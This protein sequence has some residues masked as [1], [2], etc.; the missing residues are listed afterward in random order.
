MGTTSSAAGLGA[1]LPE[2][3]GLVDRTSL[4][5]DLVAGLLGA[6]LV[7]P[8]GVA[9]ATL[10]GLPPQYGIYSAVVPC[11]VAALFGS[12]WHVM[13]G[14]TNANS[15]ALFAMLAPLAVPGSP[16]YVHLALTVTVLVGA[17]QFLVG[18]GRLG[19]LANFISPSVLLGFTCGAAALIAVHALKEFLGLTGLAGASAWTVLRAVGQLLVQGPGLAQLAPAVVGGVTIVAALLVKRLNARLPFML[20]GLL[21]GYGVA[22]LLAHLGPIAQ[23]GPIASPWPPLSL[24]EVRVE[25]LGQLGGITAALAIIALGQSI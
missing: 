11:I 20:V 10:A 1:F 25:S 15:L 8:Q 12:S 17:V 13:S 6:L 3:A 4:R 14:P 7:L 19:T 2:W 5:H 16:E 9:F 24:P 23:L 21:A 22:H 18:A